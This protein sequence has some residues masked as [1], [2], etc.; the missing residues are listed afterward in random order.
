M[1][2]QRGSILLGT[3]LLA[4][5]LVLTGTPQVVSAQ[6]EIH[7]GG[8]LAESGKFGA[9]VGPFRKLYNA[10]V[11]DVNK[12]GGLFVKSAGKKLKIL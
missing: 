7:L 4:I 1:S 3:M 11:N 8:T 6:S 2:I 5:A 10:W 12:R 9:S